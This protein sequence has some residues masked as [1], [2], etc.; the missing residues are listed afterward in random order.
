[1]MDIAILWSVVDPLV[2]SRSPSSAQHAA[3]ALTQS[4]SIVRAGVSTIAASSGP[5][6][7][8]KVVITA[9]GDD[10]SAIAASIAE[11]TASNSRPSAS[12]LS[13]LI[14]FLALSFLFNYE[15]VYSVG[16]AFV[17]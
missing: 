6:F 5:N 1:M 11:A 10:A 12:S 16:P 9:G 2:G 15:G 8:S 17:F 3:R 13:S 7:A 4:P 14:S